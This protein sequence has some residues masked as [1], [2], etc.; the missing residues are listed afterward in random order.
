MVLKRR[1]LA[2]LIAGLAVLGASAVPSLAA[3]ELK[4]AHVYETSEPYHTEALW[5][6]EE[7]ANRTNGEI[8]ISVFPASQLG[9]ENQINEGLTLGTVDIIY[10]GVAFA[11]AVHKPMAISNAPFILRDFDHW[12]AYRDSQLFQDIAAGYNQAT[13][14]KIHA[15]TYYGQRHLTANREITK[16][17]DMKGMKL[18]VPPAPLFLMFTKSVGANATPIAFAEVYLALQQKTVDGQENPL[19]TI[20]AKKFYEVQSHIMLTGHITESLVTVVGGHV[21]AQLSDEQK[22][23]F[24][25]VLKEAA[26]R[27][28][29]QIRESESRLADEFRKLGKTVVDIDRKPFIEAA[30]PL[31]MDPESGAGWTQEQYD[32]LQAL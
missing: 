25:E 5:A 8:K 15:L 4:W 19:P 11:G 29:D 7:I 27:A 10:T 23:I 18:R 12:K 6:A 22:A 9:N 26:S 14:S 28:T 24:D 3:M 17:E 2:G 1:S 13:G 16:P 21:M 32:A 30:V 31:H 20:M